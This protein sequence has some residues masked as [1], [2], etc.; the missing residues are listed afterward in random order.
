MEH[1][2]GCL[3][4]AVC[5]T[6]PNDEFVLGDEPLISGDAGA[7]VVVSPRVMIGRVWRGFLDPGNRTERVI[8]I[9][10]PT[11]VDV[12]D[13]N[14][15]MTRECRTIVSKD[16]KLGGHLADRLDHEPERDRE[17]PEPALFWRLLEPRAR[18][19]EVH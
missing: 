2:L 11:T 6:H 16:P 5:V 18:R 1:I 19:P 4:P 12:L 13:I 14:L 9:L 3:K 8:R 17:E 15:A 7:F 10:R